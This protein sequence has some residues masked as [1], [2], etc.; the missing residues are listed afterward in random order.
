[1]RSEIRRRLLADGAAL[2]FVRPARAADLPLDQFLEPATNRQILS[3]V[4]RNLKG[5]YRES[6]K[7]ERMLDDLIDPPPEVAAKRIRGRRPR[8][9]IESNRQTHAIK[10]GVAD[11]IEMRQLDPVAPIAFI[12]RLERVAEIDAAPHRERS[13]GRLA[14]RLP[15]ACR[16]GRRAKEQISAIHGRSLPR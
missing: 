4:L 15:R 10:A 11:R 6:D 7:P 1:M 9:R 14:L 2:P 16:E 3:R 5:I 12:R 8:M 13:G